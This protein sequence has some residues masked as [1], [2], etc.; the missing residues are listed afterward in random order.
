MTAR[1]LVLVVLALLL[2][3]GLFLTLRP[4]PD[5]QAQS[6]TFDVNIQGDTM[7]PPELKVREGDVVI[8]RITTDD[9]VELH[10]HGYDITQEVEPGEPTEVRFPARTTGRFE[11]ENHE[12]E[13]VLG[14][15]VVEPR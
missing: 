3:A 1:R 10:V 11:I 9:P 15:L 4:D 12:T 7:T 6:H 8:M 13:S 14:T 2:L 5:T